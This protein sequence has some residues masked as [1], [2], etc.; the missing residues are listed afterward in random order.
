MLVPFNSLPPQSR[1][2]I[3]QS[4]KA[5]TKTQIIEIEDLI[6]PFI[7]QWQRHG[8]DLKASYKIKYNQFIILAV[9][10]QNEVSGCA[11][12][13]SVHLIKNLEQKL[14]IVLTDKLQLAYRVDDA[15]CNLSVADFKTQIATSS[16]SRE[17]IIFNNMV[18]TIGALKTDWEIPLKQSWLNKFFK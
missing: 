1:I 2:W 6:I 7:E 13:A 15:I 3:Y 4:D 8:E 11:I 14:G 12:D 5:F 18:E 16:I 9:D 10:K 17:T